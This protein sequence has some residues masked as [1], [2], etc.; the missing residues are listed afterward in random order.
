MARGLQTYSHRNPSSEVNAVASVA[1]ESQIFPPARPLPGPRGPGAKDQVG[2][3]AGPD[4]FAKLLDSKPADDR[5]A[6]ARTKR[7]RSD[8]A[9]ATKGNRRGSDAAHT[10]RAK[11]KAPVEDDAPEVNETA[12]SDKAPAAADDTTQQT[13]GDAPNDAAP[14]IG[15][16]A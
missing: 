6:P 7:D 1:S 14:E 5:E 8:D 4:D 13:S 9:T 11:D 15:E 3:G 16:Q 2:A 12:A 10:K